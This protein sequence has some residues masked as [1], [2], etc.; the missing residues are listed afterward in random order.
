MGRAERRRAE[1]GTK[2]SKTA[3][4]NLTKAQL[5]AAIERG[6]RE[7]LDERKARVTED[8]IN[9]AMTLM[10]AL[11]MKVLLNDYGF[12]DE[13]PGFADKVV[14]LYEKCMNEGLDMHALREEVWDLGNVRIEVNDEK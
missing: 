7:L 11:P 4:Y 13:L 10:L 14:D 9:V 2:K 1:K 12:K 5:D 8:A 6:V 3:T